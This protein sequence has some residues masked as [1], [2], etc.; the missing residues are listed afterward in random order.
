M[1]EVKNYNDLLPISAFFLNHKYI[2]NKKIVKIICIILC[3]LFLSYKYAFPKEAGWEK[4]KLGAGGWLTGMTIHP[5]GS[6]V[7]AR[8]DVNNAWKW[9]ENTGLWTPLITS[10]SMPSNRVDWHQYMGV[11]S[12]ATAPSDNQ[13]VYMAFYNTIYKST[14]EGATWANTNFPGSDD[15][16]TVTMRPND[17]SSKLSGERLSVDPYDKNIVYFGSINKGLYVTTNGGTSWSVVPNIPVGTANRGVR[18][19]IFDSNNGISNGKTNTIYVMVDGSGIYKTTNAGISWSNITTDSGFDNSVEFTDIEIA[20]NGSIYVSAIAMGCKRYNGNTWQDITPPTSSHIMEIAVDPFDNDRVIVKA[21]GNQ[22]FFRTNNATLASPTWMSLS[23]DTPNADVPWLAWEGLGWISEGEIMFDPAVSNRLWMAEGIGSWR[24]T[25]IL[26]S[27]IS[28]K[29]LSNGQE[30]MVNNDI[31][32][33]QNGNVLAAVWDR[34]IFIKDQTNLNQ[35][36]NRYYP[37]NRFNSTWDMDVSPANPNFI[38]AITED[39]RGCC[40]DD[41]HRR[42]GYSMDGGFTWIEFAAMPE[43]NNQESIYGNIAIS[44]NDI[45]NIVWLPAYNKAA[46]YTTNRGNTWN[47]VSQPGKSN[48]CCIQANYI[49]K[50]VLVAD[51]VLP[52]T[53]YMYDWGNGNI[54]KSVDGGANWTAQGSVPA[55]AWHAKLRA[56]PGKAG[57]LLYIHGFRSDYPSYHLIHGVYIS[58]DGGQTWNEMINTDKVNNITTGKAAPNA[59]YPTIFIQ[60]T[61]NGDFGYFMSTNEGLTWSKIGTNPFGNFNYAKTMAGDPNIFGRLYVGPGSDGVFYYDANLNCPPQGTICDDGNINTIND[62]EDGSCKCT[63]T[64]LNNQFC[65]TLTPPNIDGLGN[66]WSLPSY[67]INNVLEGTIN[68]QNDLSAIFQIQWD[69]NYLYALVEVQDDNL[70][71]DSTNAYQ[72]DG[73]EIY[74]DGGNEKANTYDQNDHQLMFKYNDNNVYEW[75]NGLINPA[76]IVF[77]QTV[78][79]TSYTM[80]IRIPWSFIEANPTEGTPIGIDVHINDDDDGDNRDKKMAWYAIIDQSWNDPSLFKTMNLTVCET[81]CPAIINFENYIPN[82]THHAK[83]SIYTKAVLNVDY[84]IH[85]K[86][87]KYVHLSPGFST[88][89]TQSF[90]V[91]IEGCE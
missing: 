33:L 17:D 16:T 61:V 88:G 6:P 54:F 90:R 27:N 3:L 19:V 83:D 7:F 20:T 35:Y 87:G 75:P 31:V 74:L 41:E 51:Q 29:G 36:P 25:D 78:S 73:I 43:P 39:H 52:N 4:M 72:D 58:K 68:S 57:H 59:A 11:L 10:N 77:A 82:G 46:Y 8:S 15:N 13:V 67:N 65:N 22:P 81:N 14:N 21:Q 89:I 30:H 70:I 91:T 66:D 53:F 24:T 42:S 2:I 84:N 76:G 85:L 28:W 64:S 26:D 56:V 69:N 12:I 79:A 34:S 9:N 48:D 71:N 44:A 5:S 45:N 62:V 18:Q 50:D 49:Q 86:A 47:L 80:E 1:M 32:A 40:Y 55:W 23:W 60:G 38:V 37:N 63:G